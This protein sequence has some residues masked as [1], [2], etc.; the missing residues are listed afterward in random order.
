MPNRSHTNL[1]IIEA[2]ETLSSI[3]DLEFDRD[4]GIAQRHELILHDEKIAYKTV[5][6]LHERG[7]SETV[8]LVRETFRV[9]LHY[10]KQFYKKEYGHV[11][12]PRTIEG[13]KTIM[14]LVGEAAKKLDKYTHVFHQTHQTH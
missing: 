12:D 5:H 13:I 8:S 1:S 9:I 4:V 11:S 10:L 7:A 14:V 6:W 3:A 2:V